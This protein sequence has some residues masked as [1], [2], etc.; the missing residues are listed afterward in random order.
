MKRILL[1]ILTTVLLLSAAALVA[2]RFTD[3]RQ[4][5]HALSEIYLAALDE[6][7]ES[8]D[9]LSLTLEKLL[10]SADCTQQSLLLSR[11]SRDGQDMN[12]SLSMLPV[13]HTT[14]IETMSFANRVADYADSLLPTVVSSGMLPDDDRR[15][16]E[17]E[18]TA[19]ARLSSELA[20]ANQDLAQDIFALRLADS[21][22]GF[23][24]PEYSGAYSRAVRP[25]ALTGP[26]C[27]PDEAAAIARELLGADVMPAGETSGP[28]PAYEF[29]AADPSRTIA[30][31]RTGGKPLW[32]TQEQAGFSPQHS[33]DDCIVSAE[34]FLSRLG[35]EPMRLVW[36]QTYDGLCVL[37]YAAVES[38][39]ILYND[40][41]RVQLRMDTGAVAGF[42]ASA[43]WAN[44][45]TRTLPA[46]TLTLA[47][48]EAFVSPDVEIGQSALCLLPQYGQ[49]VL[50]YEFRVTRAGESYLIYLDAQTGREVLLQ[51][52]FITPGGSFPA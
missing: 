51:K 46:P 11:V 25:I 22:L 8:L 33:E 6:A 41:I 7:R 34:V 1:P 20:L 47:Q 16:L 30:I 19:C 5:Q 45:V 21:P 10:I 3:A 48:A 29:T 38:E 37:T 40:L 50:C 23:P 17:A 24:V 39:I 14:L 43:Y 49:E 44:H 9:D 32:M 18:L 26:E 4:K 2:F 12:R 52:I 27:S 42:D 31:T 36:Q 15:Q 13:D 28:L 35:A